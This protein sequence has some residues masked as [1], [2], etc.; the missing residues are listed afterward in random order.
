MTDVEI[1]AGI[2]KNYR[3]RKQRLLEAVQSEVVRTPEAPRSR[4]ETCAM[5]C[6]KEHGGGLFLYRQRDGQELVVGKR[7]AQY[8]DYLRAHPNRVRE[9]LS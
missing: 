1:E 4:G 6:L 5:C 2:R 3:V 7:C 8:L 9:L